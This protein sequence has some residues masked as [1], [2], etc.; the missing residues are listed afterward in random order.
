MKEVVV[1]ETWDEPMADMAV[2]LLRA[3]GITAHKRDS[4]LRSSLALTVDGL[5]EIEV[6]VPAEDADRAAEIL[7]ARFS[8]TDDTPDVGA[9]TDNHE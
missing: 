6:R 9:D 2:G 7:A 5:G 1:L 4:G 8:E 3:E